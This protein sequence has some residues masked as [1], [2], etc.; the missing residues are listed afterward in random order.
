MTPM[1]T[2]KPKALAIIICDEV[3]DDRL[4]N[5]KTLV[6]T[7]NNITAPK[8]PCRHHQLHVFVALTDGHGAYNAKLVCKH[9]ESNTQTFEAG[10][11]IKFEDPNQVIEMNFSLQG[12]VF[13]QYGL[14]DFD[15]YCNDQ[16]IIGRKFTVS[17]PKPEP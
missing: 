7:F 3:I 6:G 12:L 2:G 16:H 13:M 9:R 5:K 11:D 8:V 17:P 10:G 14:H 4:T 15:I 1:G